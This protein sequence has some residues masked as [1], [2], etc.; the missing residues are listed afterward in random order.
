[1]FLRHVGFY[2]RFIKDFA[3]IAMPLTYLLDKETPLYLD[4]DYIAY[5]ENLKKKLVSTPIM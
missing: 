3:K 4:H 5:F 2:K 1:M